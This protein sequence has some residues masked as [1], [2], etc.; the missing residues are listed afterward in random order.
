LKRE[1]IVVQEPNIEYNGGHWK[2]TRG[3]G[4]EGW[5]WKRIRLQEIGRGDGEKEKRFL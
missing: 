1:D 2:G 5:G 4:D 3:V